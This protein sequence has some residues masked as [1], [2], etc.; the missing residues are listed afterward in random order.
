MDHGGR[1]EKIVILVSCDVR[2]RVRGQGYVGIRQVRE[3]SRIKVAPREDD[4]K[5]RP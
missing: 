4:E 3:Q 1:S 5:T 2:T